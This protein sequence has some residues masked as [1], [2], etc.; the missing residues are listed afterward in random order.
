VP[1]GRYSSE[2]VG[3]LYPSRIC[4][5]CQPPTPVYR[6]LC[7]TRLRFSFVILCTAALAAAAAPAH[8]Q[9]SGQAGRSDEV[10]W[11]LGPR[12]TAD[13]GDIDD[14]ALGGALRVGSPSFPVQGSGAFD[15]YLSDGGATV[16]T[17]DLNGQIPIEVEPWFLPYVGAGLGITRESGS[18]V[19]GS[20]TD[21][22][23]TSWAGQRSTFGSSIR[24][25]RPR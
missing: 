18:A 12:F 25:C 11:K 20:T 9:T 21:L 16:F 7:P 22:G 17:V 3:A 8:G 5:L 19:G 6:L 24:S 1:G 15:L 10:N 13:A 23:S 14:V 4:A 2:N